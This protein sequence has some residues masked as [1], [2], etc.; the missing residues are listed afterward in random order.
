MKDTL[1]D[2]R[3]QAD[4]KMVADYVR[5][6]KDFVFCEPLSPYEH[7][8]ATVLDATLQ[9]GLNYESV[10]RPRVNRL[11]QMYP[12]AKTTTAFFDLLKT[13]TL[14]ELTNWTN[15]EKLTRMR[16]VLDLLRDEK[17]ETESGLAEWLK[18]EANQQKMKKCRGIKNKTLDYYKLLTGGSVLAID[19][20]LYNFLRLVGVDIE[21]DQYLRAQNILREVATL[22][23]IEERVLDH[24]IWKYM[25]SSTRSAPS[26]CKRY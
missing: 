12:D 10:V 18:S 5:R 6:S 21:N 24:S 2:T 25:T 20:H 4:A 14:Q 9:A 1:P 16:C 23:N 13:V 22:L 11:R 26:V 3:I 17:I 7:M 15:V 8:G 19:R